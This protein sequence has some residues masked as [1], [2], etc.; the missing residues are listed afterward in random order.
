VQT[1]WNNGIASGFTGVNATIE[2]A[3]AP[4][5]IT[6]NTENL[7]FE[8]GTALG[9]PAKIHLENTLLGSNCYV[10]SNAQPIQLE[11]TTGPSGSLHGSTGTL[12]GNGGFTRIT[13][14]GLKL[15]DNIFAAPA[16]SGCGGIYS[17]LVDPLIDSIFGLPASSEE[18]WL[19]LEG[20][21]RIG[22]AAEVFAFAMP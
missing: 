4:S 21:L 11:L 15:V 6:L 8:E 5:S 7:L 2:L 18:S 16:A 20:D 9:L 14:A 1:W 17:S 13:F 22:E 19:I 12:S 3:A 10:G